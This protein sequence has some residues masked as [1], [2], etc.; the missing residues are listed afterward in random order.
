M[1]VTL[2]GNVIS[3]EG[4]LEGAAGSA[5][6]C[7][8]IEKIQ[9]QGCSVFVDSSR[10]KGGNSRGLHVYCS[11]LREKKAPPLTYVNMSTFFVTMFSLSASLLR[12]ADQIHSMTLRLVRD[13]GELLERVFTVGAEIPLLADYDDYAFTFEENGHAFEL[14]SQPSDVFRSLVIM[15][16]VRNGHA[17]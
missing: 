6:F 4:R 2:N 13:D 1:K 17:A 9:A 16:S 14:D 7:T 15:F 5:E 11:V 12:P 8:A 3:L 10:L